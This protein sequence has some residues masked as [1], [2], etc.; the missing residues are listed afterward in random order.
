MYSKLLLIAALFCLELFS[1]QNI[2]RIEFEHSNAMI[3]F[4]SIDIVFEPIRDHKKGK[5]GVKVKK[6]RHQ[7][8]SHRISKEKFERIYNA[9]QKIEYDTVAVT[10]NFIDPS[11][12]SIIL[13]DTVG[14]RKSFHAT[15]LNQRSKDRES[16]KNFWYATKLIIKAARL[17]M[18]DLIGYERS[19]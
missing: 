1:S 3:V 6:G 5:I 16:Q 7:E 15:G 18:K 17:E 13:H 8:Y 4:S 19:F 11:S 9:I 10:N 12:S 2:H 14:N